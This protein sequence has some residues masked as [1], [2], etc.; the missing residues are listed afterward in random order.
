MSTPTDSAH[1]RRTDDPAAPG[2]WK[3][4]LLSG[5]LVFLIALPLCLGISMASGFPAIAGIFTA[6]IG[7]L[8][9]TWMGSAPL[10]IKGPAAGLI[11]IALGAVTELGHGDLS[12]GYH[13]ALAAI[14]VAGALQVAMALLRAGSLGDF[15]PAS[16]VH[17][18]LAAI[19]VIIFGKQVHVMLGVRPTATEPLHLLSEIPRSIAHMNP[20]I[21]LIGASAL[22]LMFALPLVKNRWV[23]R[24]PAPLIALAVSVALGRWFDL[25]HAHH[26]QLQAHDY[27]VGPAFLLQLPGSLVSAVTRPDF[28]GILSGLGFK[29]VVMFTLVGSIESLL[30]AKA[31]D[32][33]D[34][35][36]R[37]SDLDKDLL[38]TGIGNMLCGLVG[39]LPM[40]SEI[41]RSSANV[42][43]GGRTRRANFFHGGFLL[44]FVGAAPWLLARI[45]LA[46][47]AAMLVYT[48]ARLASPKEFARSLQVGPEQALI[49]G[50]TFVGTLGVDILVGVAA[51]ILVKAVVHTLAGLRL[52]Q[53]F[54][55]EMSVQGEGDELTVRVLGAAVFTN[56]VSMRRRIDGLAARRVTLDFSQAQLVDHTVLERLAEMR[57]A[58]ITENRELVVV[59]LNALRPVG[60]HPLAARR[61]YA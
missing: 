54:V 60:R 31:V 4:D 50:V 56:I 22:G 55:P 58:W 35:W 21:A 32:T 47:L 26:Y 33:L 29:Y 30:S 42:N 9:T 43:N 61:R 10:T 36:R 34:P 23:R 45:P 27:T 20:E 59:G 49:F 51:G 17:G 18:M 1:A 6:V 37:R 13:R 52:R 39:A 5:F 3:D 44:L 25:E 40:I 24:V 48:G 8:L 57:S 11:V 7:G 53:L 28:S 15:F 12:L 41:V 16:V 2:S 19:G 46:A 14:V 38:A